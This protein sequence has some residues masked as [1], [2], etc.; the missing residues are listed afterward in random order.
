MKNKIEHILIFAQGERGGTDYVLKSLA[1]WLAKNG[2]SVFFADDWSKIEDQN[3]TLIILPTS[4][5]SLIPALRKRKSGLRCDKFIIWCMGCLAFHDAYYN[6][7]ESNNYPR[8]LVKSLDILIN[9]TARSLFAE[10]SLIFTDEVGMYADLIHLRDGSADLSDVIFPIPIKLDLTVKPDRFS[11]K[12][13][14]IAWIG[15]IDSDFKILPLIQLVEDVAAARALGYFDDAL[16]FVIVGSGDAM[17]QLKECVSKISEIHFEFHE[18]LSSDELNSLLLARVDI[19]FAMGSSALLGASLGVPT[20]IV[21]PYSNSDERL[22]ENYRWVDETVGHS[23]GEFPGM[24]CKPDQ[25]RKAFGELF[26]SLSIH[27]KSRLSR[28]FSRKFDEDLVFEALLK[29]ELPIDTSFKSRFLL[30][31]LDL[32]FSFKVV[33]KRILSLF[34]K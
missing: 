14:S 33:A 17:P 8:F 27:D 19:L 24:F 15:R 20:V 30:E 28:D 6:G 26:N 21:Q 22:I 31:I 10:R 18:W 16:T 2:Y 12:P 23:L 4:R 13:K 32:I 7:R 25:V 3:Y 11:S 9:A 5:M 1:D 34:N 29:R